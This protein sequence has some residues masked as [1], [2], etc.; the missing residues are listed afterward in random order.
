MPNVPETLDI[1]YEDDDLLVLNK[2]PGISVHPSLHESSGTLVD[3]LL[4]YFPELRGVG[5]DPVRP[6]IVHRLDKDTSGVLVIAKNQETF[7]ELKELFRS[8]KIEKQY[9]AIVEG[10]VKA[11]RGTITLPI[12]RIGMRRGVDGPGRP[13]GKVREAITNFV[14]RRRFRDATLLTLRPKTGRMHQ[15]R[16]HLAAIGHPVL[17]DKLYG[18]KHTSLRASRQMLHASSLTLSRRNGKR[19]T[20]EADPPEDFQETLG[21]LEEN[22]A[23]YKND[24][25]FVHSEY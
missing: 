23:K 16:V 15:L 8:R 12:G 11:P 25:E 10:R 1:L 4:S 24:E 22:A 19:Y 14:V 18:G 20:F 7:V 6:G 9:I 5:E 3:A 2:P 17:G 21:T 13:L